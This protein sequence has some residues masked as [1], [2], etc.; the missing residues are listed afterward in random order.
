[1]RSALKV[2]ARLRLPTMKVVELAGGH[3]INME[4][5]DGFTDAVAEFV[6]GLK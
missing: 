6:A 3:S 2:R 4:A 1:M 5:P